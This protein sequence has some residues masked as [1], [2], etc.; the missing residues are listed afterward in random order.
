MLSILSHLTYS[1][2]PPN[3]RTIPTRDAADGTA[4]RRDINFEA[5]PQGWS[6]DARRY[7][8]VYRLPSRLSPLVPCDRIIEIAV[9]HLISKVLALWRLPARANSRSAVTSVR[10]S[11]NAA[12]RCNASKVRSELSIEA[13]NRRAL[14]KCSVFREIR[15]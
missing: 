8:L 15:R 9:T 1:L 10:P 6:C 2:V 7:L 4:S 5:R 11:A 3:F 14:I 12:A 13:T